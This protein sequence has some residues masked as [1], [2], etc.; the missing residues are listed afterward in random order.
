MREQCSGW[1]W[2][3]QEKAPPQVLAPRSRARRLLALPPDAPPDSP[4]PPQ[5]SPPSQV[6]QEQPSLA[7][8]QQASPLSSAAAAGRAAGRFAAV[9]FA[10]FSASAAASFAASPSKMFPR[11]LGLV[12][13]ERARVRLL[14]G[15]ADFRQEID[16]HLRLNLEFPCQF[17]NSNLIRICHQPLFSPYY[18][19][20]ARFAA[21]SSDSGPAYFAFT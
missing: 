19:E 4:E 21:S 1:L 17:V 16:Q 12:E 10:C 20:P 13:I 15:D 8:P 6:Q 5:A 11:E 9:D 3:E 14:F 7:L 18:S 2:H